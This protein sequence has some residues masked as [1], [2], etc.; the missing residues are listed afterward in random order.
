M[1][2]YT[3]TGG[4]G[5]RPF[6]PLSSPFT[7]GNM[8]RI[9]VPLSTGILKTCNLQAL[10]LA[11]PLFS[12]TSK[13]LHCRRVGDSPCPWH[14]LWYI[15]R[16]EESHGAHSQVVYE[17]E[18]PGGAAPGGVPLRGQ[19]SVYSQGRRNRGRDS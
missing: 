5:A 4:R 13:T 12:T 2:T 9:F 17:R 10:R 16:S 7:K 8:P 18:E 14:I 1:R 6:Q 11:A 19:R 15:L 3:K